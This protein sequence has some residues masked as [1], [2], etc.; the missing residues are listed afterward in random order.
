MADL[1]GGEPDAFADGG[2]LL[3]VFLV[4]GKLQF[5]EHFVDEGLVFF[6]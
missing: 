6:G 4:L 1:R 2:M 5:F 3:A